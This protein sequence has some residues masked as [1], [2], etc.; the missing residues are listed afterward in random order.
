MPAPEVTTRF[1]VIV[2]PEAARK[3]IEATVPLRLVAIFPALSTTSAYGIDVPDATRNIEFPE[4]ELSN[5]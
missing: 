3:P 2:P 1:P 5:K 4:A